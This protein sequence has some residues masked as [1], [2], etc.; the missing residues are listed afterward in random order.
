MGVAGIVRDLHVDGGRAAR[1]DFLVGNG[2]DH[3]GVV[4]DLRGS[5]AELQG[6][7]TGTACLLEYHYVVR[8]AAKNAGDSKIQAALFQACDLARIVH[9]PMGFFGAV[10]SPRTP[11][12][13]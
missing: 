4:A 2:L 8:A 5:K 3:R 7:V 12:G 6:V 9:N 10:A 11:P 1:R 13:S